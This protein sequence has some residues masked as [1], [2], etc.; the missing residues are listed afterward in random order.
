LI[1]FLRYFNT[2]YIPHKVFTR[3]CQYEYIP[4]SPA[5]GVKHLRPIH[6]PS[7]SAYIFPS[8]LSTR[9]GQA[10]TSYPHP[11][12]VSLYIPKSSLEQKGSS[13]YVLSTSHLC[14]PIYS[15]VISPP[16]GVKHLH[17][18]H[19][20]PPSAYIFPSHLYSRRGQALTGYPHPIS[21]SLHIPKSSLQQKGSS[22]YV[23]PTSHLCQPI[24]SQVISVAERVKH[25][26]PIHIPSI[27]AYIFP[28]HLST[29]RG[30]TLTHYPHPT[31]VSLYIPK[32]SLEQKGS[33][34]Y[35]LSTSHLCQPTY[36]QVIST[37]EG[38]KHLRSIH[39][40]SVSLYIPKSSFQQKGSS[41][42]VLPTSHLCQLYIPC[43]L[44]GRRGQ[45]LTPYPH[46]ASVSLHIP[47]SSLQ[48]KG[49]S[50]YN[51][52]TSR[53]CQPTYPQVIS[54]AEGVK[55]LRPIHI[56]S[57]SAYIS[58][59]HLFSRRGQALTTCPC[60]ISVS[61]YIPPSHL[62]TRRIQALTCL[63]ST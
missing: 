3:F 1:R 19:I 52:S 24:Y 10:L 63:F 40:I 31:S 18:I 42:Y 50:T 56:P 11:I 30:Q 54:S 23:L 5:E 45:A 13:T 27:S 14:Q 55:H 61:L 62:S 8:Y 16:E 47:K 43:H 38:V 17:T 7:L 6:I 9:R 32:S 22:T 25:L 41:T 59:S 44:A 37:A 35:R 2:T 48:Q 21:V 46:P 26:R 33:S 39:P 12:S 36:P 15:Q 53:L 51:L 20:P 4:N 29:G 28:S 49:S 34:T 60:P 58:P 57:L